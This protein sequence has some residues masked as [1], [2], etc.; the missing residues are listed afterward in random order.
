MATQQQIIKTLE[1]E[2]PRLFQYAS[3]RLHSI[4]D[5]EDAMQNLYVKCLSAPQKFDNIENLRAYLFRTLCNDCNTLLKSSSKNAVEHIESF[6]EIT[7]EEV[8]P[9]NFDEEFTLINKLLTLIPR[10]QSE[11]IRLRM[12]SGLSF[13]EIADVMACPLPTAKARFR[14]GIEKLRDGLKKENLL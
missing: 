14:Y 8:Q 10:E 12:H 7:P 4:E 9:E 11:V 5:V 6:A 13:Q 3:Y 1:S 2:K